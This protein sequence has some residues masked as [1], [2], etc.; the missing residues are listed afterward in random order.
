MK[1]IRKR[2]ISFMLLAGI[3]CSTAVYGSILHEQ[4]TQQVITKG[5][6][7]INDKLLM[8]EGWRN[9]NVLKI[10]LND[11]NV[12]LKP[13]ESATGVERQTVLQMVNNAGAIAGVNADYFDMSTSNTPSLGTYIEGGVLKHGY[14]SNYSELGINKSMA[15][16]TLDTNNTPSMAYYGVSIRINANGNF[17][18]GAATKNN[19]P[20]TITRPIIVDSSYYKTTNNIVTKHKSVYT[21]VVENDTVIYLAKAGE[22][23]TIP[24][25][26]YVILVPETSANEYYTKMPIG[27]SVDLQ[28]FLYVG[29]NVITAIN[30]LKLGI[31]GSGIIMKNGMAYTG[32]AHKVTPNSAVARTIIATTKGSNEIL[33]ITID[34]KGSY[35]GVTHN[36]LIEILQR[37][38]VDNAM[39]L[40]GGGSTT[41]VARNL[42]EKEVKLQNNPSDGSQRK[43]INGLGVFSNSAPG[44]ISTLYIE[45]TYSRTFIGENITLKLKGIDENSNPVTID[46]S[47]V[48]FSV[49][50]GSGQFNGATFTPSSEGKLM[51]IAQYNGAQAATE[52][53]VSSAPSGLVIEP[54]LVQLNENSTK[55]VQVYGLDNEGYKIPLKAEN[56]SWTSANSKLAATN[57]TIVSTTNTLGKLTANYKGITK[58]IG[59]IVGNTAV[60]LESFETNGATWAGD[61]S[62]V[63]GKVEISKDDKYHGNQALKMTYTFMP[64]ANKQVAY[65]V[66]S[67]PIQIP[68]DAASINMWLKAKKQGHVA[69][70]E[71]V[72]KAGKTFY[73]KLADSL[74]FDGWK[75]VS[76]TLPQEISLPAKVT[77]LYTY[78]N[79]NATKVTTTLYIDHVSI[80]RGFRDTVGIATR[81]D[82][83]ADPFYKPTLQQAIQNQYIINAVGPTKVSSMMLGKDTLASISKQLSEGAGAVLLASNSNSELSL[84]AP[85]YVY[86]NT[87]EA[88]D[89]NNTKMIMLGT[90]NGGLRTTQE[91]A[92]IYLKQSLDKTNAKHIILVMSKNPLTQFNDALEGQALHEYLKT[93]KESTGRNIFVV[94]TGGSENEVRIEDGIR[95]IRTHGMNV[96]TDNYKEGTFLKFKI[97]GDKIYYT[98]EKFK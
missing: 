3:S 36:Q 71:V 30:E 50:G 15:T 49:E 8:S 58:E 6:V 55:T 25:N 69:K 98:F 11:S 17:V 94:T 78:S 32:S 9:I 91:Q 64:S 45:P 29:D 31:G 19:I 84:G 4:R 54:S 33:L 34:G 92:W 48:K 75:Y 23:V 40:D 70:I 14:N 2:L 74:D 62:S 52:I 80:T 42:G 27:T 35:T 12:S 41:F 76:A 20:N 73:L 66:F 88:I 81:N 72:D 44:E 97:D 38:N 68:E 86:K 16:F 7:H 93:Y 47:K 65:T 37:Y 22:S 51:V 46:T 59:V 85:N 53:K 83:S 43:V 39:Y 77:K 21:I 90:G 56:V 28:E 18:G 79:S 87:Y 5:A 82:T 13:M 61:T 24:T 89:Y 95:Y 1:G 57:N 60:P 26:G 63:V 10:D 67:N 96:T